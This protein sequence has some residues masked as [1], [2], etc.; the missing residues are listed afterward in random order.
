[1]Q[2]LRRMSPLAA[3]LLLPMAILAGIGIG[4]GTLRLLAALF[5]LSVLS[6]I[7]QCWGL[8]V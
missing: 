8:Q 7:A 6:L 4:K 2:H 1:M 3:L 5:L